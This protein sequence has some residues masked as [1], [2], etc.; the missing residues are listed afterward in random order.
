MLLGRSHSPRTAPV[1]PGARIVNRPQPR[2]FGR[3]SGTTPRKVELRVTLLLAQQDWGHSLCASR[4]SIPKRW[5]TGI[6]CAQ[7]DTWGDF[8]RPIGGM[9]P[10]PIGGQPEAVASLAN[11]PLCCIETR[12]RCRAV[13]GLSDF[14]A[15]PF[16]AA[17][18]P[19]PRGPTSGG[20]ARTG[21]LVLTFLKAS[22]PL[23]PS[24]NILKRPR[25][26]S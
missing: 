9:D 11:D 8:P 1:V 3:T 20:S 18:E 15:Y 26:I 4:L 2:D 5:R 17:V 19:P 22:L 14:A 7:K 10:G 16:Q 25:P 23:D 24:N 12:F 6:G 13:V 21:T